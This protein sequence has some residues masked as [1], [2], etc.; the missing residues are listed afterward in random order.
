M[1]TK[2]KKSSNSIYYLTINTN[3]RFS[4]WSADTIEF[5]NQFN[6]IIN[7]KFSEDHIFEFV[8]FKEGAIS[9]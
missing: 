5:Y 9:D 1:T 7:Y 8:T 2:K 3:R 4:N 6:D